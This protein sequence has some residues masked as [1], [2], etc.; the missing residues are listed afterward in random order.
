MDNRKKIIKKCLD[1]LAKLRDKENKIINKLWEE[2]NKDEK[3]RNRTA[4]NNSKQRT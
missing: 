1:A 2:I 4:H 3:K